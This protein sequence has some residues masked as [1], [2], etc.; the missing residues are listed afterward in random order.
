MLRE[1]FT[2]LKFYLFSADKTFRQK[3]CAKEIVNTGKMKIKLECQIKIDSELDGI[4]LSPQVQNASLR[5]WKLSG[6]VFINLSLIWFIV[7]YLCSSFLEASRLLYLPH[8][9]VFL[10]PQDLKALLTEGAGSSRDV[11]YGHHLLIRK[12]I[13]EGIDNTHAMSS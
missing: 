5:L 13:N 6:V 3:V 8:G 1:I 4:K 10:K 2:A 12:L 11:I 7:Y 9:L